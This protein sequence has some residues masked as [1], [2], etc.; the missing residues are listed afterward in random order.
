MKIAIITDTHWSVKKGSKHFHDYF[1]LFYKNIFFPTLEERGIKTVI[2]MGD[3]FDNRKGIDF[4]GLDW[5]RRVVLEPLR[6][7]EVHMIVGNHDI[8]FRNSTI[9]NAPELLLNDYQNIKI[10]S[11]PKE[12][13]IAGM[14]SLILPWIC[15]DNEEETFNLIQETKAKVVFAHLELSGFSAYPGHIMTDGLSAE[16]FEK[17]E[18][19]FTGHYHTKSDNGKV[20]YLGN[21][22]Q[23][24]WNDVDDTR[25]F[26]IFDTDTYDI[27]YFKNPYNIFERIYYEDSG[28]K[29]IDSSIIKDKIVKIIVRKKTNQL[30][31]DK[32]VDKIVKSSPL[33]LKVVEIID[34]DDEN[35]N[36]EEI[37]AED[38]LSILDKYVEEAE[39]NLDKT[40]IKK[41]LRD[42]YKEALEL[43]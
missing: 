8:F 22:Y 4:W 32:F 13:C 43:N 28:V 30:N 42:V 34:V 2:H 24:F 25:G 3:A 36:C 7:Y 35:V 37:S 38:T 12:I 10:Y 41:L 5:T 15:S 29:Q 17:F 1:E 39:F 27:E 26:H 9:I 11:S 6:K 23:M 16:K 18:K 19:V 21:P 40:I 31:F 20:F 33:D 14:N